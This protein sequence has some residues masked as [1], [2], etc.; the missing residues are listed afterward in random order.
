MVGRCAP[1][2]IEHLDVVTSFGLDPLVE[3]KVILFAE[4]G[5]TPA[6]KK[7]Q[8]TNPDIVNGIANTIVELL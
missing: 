3:I 1:E 2:V 6:L 4:F 7:L 8:D 5:S